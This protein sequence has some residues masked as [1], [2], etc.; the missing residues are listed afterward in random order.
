M[1]GGTLSFHLAHINNASDFTLVDYMQ[2]SIEISKKNNRKF[3]DKF[4]FSQGDIYN[5]KSPIGDQ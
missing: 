5:L 3:S 4:S 1:A 2:E